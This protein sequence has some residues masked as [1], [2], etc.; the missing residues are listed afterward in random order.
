MPNSQSIPYSRCVLGGCSRKENRV[1]QVSNCR[2]CVWN[3]SNSLWGGTAWW[4]S[5]RWSTRWTSARPFCWGTEMAICSP[6]LERSCRCYW[7]K[8]DTPGRRCSSCLRIET[9][10]RPYKIDTIIAKDICSFWPPPEHRYTFWT[11]VGSTWWWCAI[12]AGQKRGF[13]PQRLE[14]IPKER[15][16]FYWRLSV[17]LVWCGMSWATVTTLLRS[18]LYIFYDLVDW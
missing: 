9:H 5:S 14:W 15:T 7:R 8:E 6:S 18:L 11:R 13:L 1:W 4:L 3:L 16:L 17:F 10:R 2:R 12:G